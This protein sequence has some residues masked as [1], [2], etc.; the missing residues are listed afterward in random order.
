MVDQ[1]FIFCMAIAIT[2]AFV[3]GLAAIL[4][5]VFLNSDLDASRNETPNCPFGRKYCPFGR[6]FASVCRKRPS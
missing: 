2:L 3:L 1:V 6:N 5:F 4:L